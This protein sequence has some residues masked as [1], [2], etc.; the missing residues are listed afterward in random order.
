VLFKINSTF[1][2]QKAATTS[3]TTS[4]NTIPR[5]TIEPCGSSTSTQPMLSLA[6][7]RVCSLH[8]LVSKS[9]TSSRNSS[10]H[11]PLTHSHSATDNNPKLAS[12][13]HSHWAL[14]HHWSISSLITKVIVITAL[15]LVVR[16]VVL[17]WIS[18]QQLH[19]CTFKWK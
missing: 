16:V 17:A 2:G 5:L 7:A 6:L 4:P 8:H 15:P 13:A 14:L 11:H 12:D 9:Y 1:I 18:R 3:L 10:P 19:R